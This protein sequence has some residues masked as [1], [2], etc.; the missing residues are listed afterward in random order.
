[1]YLPGA[2]SS[3]SGS[4]GPVYIRPPGFKF[5]AQEVTRPRLKKKKKTFSVTKPATLSH[6]QQQ[7]DI[8]VLNKRDA[9]PPKH[10]PI[11]RGMR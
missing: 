9:T 1:M 3:C 2:S 11:K 10:R 8:H 7:H 6:S 4:S 5:H